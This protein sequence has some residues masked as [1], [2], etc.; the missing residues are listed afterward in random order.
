MQL[1]TKLKLRTMRS[2]C[3]L[4][5]HNLGKIAA[6]ELSV[7]SYRDTFDSTDVDQLNNFVKIFSECRKIL[8]KSLPS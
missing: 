7:A 6:L 3:V 4:P 5:R 2:I 1:N 8:V